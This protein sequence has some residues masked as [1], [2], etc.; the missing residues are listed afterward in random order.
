M[1]VNGRLKGVVKADITTATCAETNHVT[2]AGN[3]ETCSLGD[4]VPSPG[5][6]ACFGL[7]T[8]I[9]AALSKE[10]TVS[11]EPSFISTVKLKADNWV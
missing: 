3:R 7:D 1:P 11:D 2:G 10:S 4:L 9:W 6:T 8:N 5:K